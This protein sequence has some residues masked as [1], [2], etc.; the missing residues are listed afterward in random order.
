MNTVVTEIRQTPRCMICEHEEFIPFFTIGAFPVV[1]NILCRTYQ[2]AVQIPKGTIDLVY[3]PSCQMIFNREFD[4]QLVDYK[5]DYENSLHFSPHFEQY[6]TEL[7]NHLVQQYQISDKRVIEIGCG[8]GDFLS[9]LCR[10]GNNQGTGFDPTYTPGEQ[11]QALHDSVTIVSDAYHED[12]Y[13]HTADFLCSRHVLEHIRQPLDFIIQLKPILQNSPEGVM[14]IE[15]PN[16]MYT[17]RQLGIWDIIYEHCNYFN[18]HSLKHLIREAGFEPV[19]SYELYQGQFIGI[20]ARPMSLQVRTDD[21]APQPSLEMEPLVNRFGE[22]YREKV[23]TWRHLLSDLREQRKKVVLWG[24]GSKGV[25]FLNILDIAHE[26]VEYVV[27]IN[28]RK[29]GCYICGSG[30][31]IVPP[32]FLQDYQPDVII[33]MNS[34]YQDEV[35]SAIREMGVT[36]EIMVA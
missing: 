22:V 30:Q 32:S 26:A 14:Y 20:E 25:N 3:C 35:A 24:A 11:E 19:Q 23:H 13:P 8:R 21:P 27:D 31:Q 36:A 34:V 28:P 5:G 12:R 6:A 9:L 17:I 33:L 16:V 7:A 1:C 2:E 10:L 4:A 18:I 15:V 29:H